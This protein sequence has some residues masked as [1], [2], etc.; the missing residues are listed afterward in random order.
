MC[1]ASVRAGARF[2]PQCGAQFDG[3][4]EVLKGVDTIIEPAATAKEIVLEAPAP[5]AH[6]LTGDERS[7]S[8]S[9]V[10]KPLT[11]ERREGSFAAH[12]SD[13]AHTPEPARSAVPHLEESPLPAAD[14]SRIAAKEER[15][16]VVLKESPRPRVERVREAS[17]I[18]AE[19][20]SEDSGLRFV[21]VAL[22]LFL[23]FLLLLFLNAFIK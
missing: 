13:G 23:G 14:A 4:A 12:V 18:V 15:A 1:G 3:E 8:G 17:L 2:C 20:A 10:N 11:D 21:L 9:R 5:P 7:E 22:V 16:G 6:K 19:D